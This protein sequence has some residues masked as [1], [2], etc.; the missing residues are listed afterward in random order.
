[1]VGGQ[2]EEGDVDGHGCVG[3]TTH[4][5]AAAV[6]VVGAGEPDGHGCEK[7]EGLEGEQDLYWSL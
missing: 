4:E 2:R 3:G 5:V 6:A 1:M 7:D